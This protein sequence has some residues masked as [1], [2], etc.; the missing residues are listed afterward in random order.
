M[1]WPDYSWKTEKGTFDAQNGTF[2]PAE[3]ETVD[4]AYI[5]AVK[6]IVRNKIDYSR[7][8]QN[9]DYFNYLSKARK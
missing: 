7:Q 3:G 1:L 5:T 6:S 4:E 2:T 9:L 8:V